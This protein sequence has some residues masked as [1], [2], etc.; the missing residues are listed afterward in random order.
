MPDLRRLLQQHSCLRSAPHG[1]PCRRPA[2]MPHGARD[3]CPRDGRQS[4]RL[5]GVGGP[6]L[7]ACVGGSAPRGG[8]MTPETKRCPACDLELHLGAFGCDKSRPPFFLQGRCKP[9]TSLANTATRARRLERQKADREALGFTADLADIVRELA[10]VPTSEDGR[11][12]IEMP[13]RR[14]RPVAYKAAAR[15]GWRNW[16]DLHYS[17]AVRVNKNA[18]PPSRGHRPQTRMDAGSRVRPYRQRSN[19]VGEAPMVT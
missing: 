9:C 17:P 11:L 6:H 1:R 19:A 12:V 8:L 4:G 7:P 14:R 3:A 10:D 5:L 2:A 13:D 18:G 15:E 16:R